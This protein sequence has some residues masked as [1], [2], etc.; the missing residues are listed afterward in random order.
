MTL[1]ALLPILNLIE[2][3]YPNLRGKCDSIR[4]IIHAKN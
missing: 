4:A 3:L 2:R 1:S